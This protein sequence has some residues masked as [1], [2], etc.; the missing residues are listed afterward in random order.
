MS[1][2]DSVCCRQRRGNTG[3]AFQVKVSSLAG[4]M[5]TEMQQQFQIVS[6]KAMRHLRRSAVAGHH[7][8]VFTIWAW[9]PFE[10]SYRWTVAV[11]RPNSR[12]IPHMASYQVWR[13]DLDRQN[14]K[15]P[16]EALR[17]PQL[18][19]PTIHGE[20]VTLTN[21]DVENFL[22]RLRGITIPFY[23]K[24]PPAIT[25]DGS[26]FEF[27]Y[28]E[29]FLGG[30]LRWWDDGPAEWR[31][32]TEVIRKIAQELEERRIAEADEREQRKPQS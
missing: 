16:F 26:K 25:S 15:S 18:M 28:D 14:F 5:T 3:L 32:L 21:D 19:E 9:Q 17:H 31:P 22:H 23:L 20:S 27:K 2:P 24:R 1:I 7:R 10:P 11:A 4:G 8:E 30:T 6:A 12:W 13:S 29:W